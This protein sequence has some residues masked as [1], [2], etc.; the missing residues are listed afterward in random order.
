MD[1]DVYHN[2][3]NFKRSLLNRVRRLIYRVLTRVTGL[4]IAG[5]SRQQ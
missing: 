3:D 5:S 1:Q 2:P 4:R